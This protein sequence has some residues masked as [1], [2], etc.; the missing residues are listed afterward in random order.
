MAANI[1]DNQIAYKG[2]TPWHGLG[3]RVDETATGMEML[4]SAGLNWPVEAR[5]IAMR[6]TDA[7][8]SNRNLVIPG[9][10]AITRG[11]TQQVFHVASD[12]YQPVQNA[13]I[14]E[15][16]HS[17]C[18]AGHATMDVVGALHGGAVVW[19]L[20]NINGG[21][22]T[23]LKGGDKLTGKI[24]LS[25]SHDGSLQT[26]GRGTQVRVVCNNTFDAARS[27]GKAPFKLKHSAKFTDAEKERCRV[28]MADEIGNVIRA[29]ENAAA[30]ANVTIDE[31][32]W[33]DFMCK[34]MGDTN[35]IS[36]KDGT[37]TKVAREIKD[38]TILSPG[39]NL[40][41]ARGTL[42]GAVNGVTY[43]AD[44][45]RGRTA[46]SRMMSAWFGNS[47]ELKNSAVNV[48]LDMAGIAR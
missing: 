24:L 1:V 39:A 3:V 19:A 42:W 9:Y 34:L 10:K 36:V 20:A 4:I 46:D 15:M 25:T 27:A 44:H 5:T 12:R 7:D 41:S 29:N 32:A 11:D 2:E 30:L 14:I 13:E 48:A 47:N 6:N 8:A 40:E 37:L 38:D 18:E 21:S 33:L 28:M 22:T 35:V 43:Y 17:F 23:T 26:E 31:S 16:F 45:R